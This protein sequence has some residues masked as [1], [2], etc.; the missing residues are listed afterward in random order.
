M[1]VP[2]MEFAIARDDSPLPQPFI[3]PVP[4][5]RRPSV[6]YTYD[7]YKEWTRSGEPTEEWDYPE[8]SKD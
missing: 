8:G 4:H 2:T 6:E 7:E 1:I 3:I 5:Q